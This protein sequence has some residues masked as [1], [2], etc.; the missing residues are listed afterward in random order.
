MGMALKSGRSIK[1]TCENCGATYNI[2]EES[3][4]TRDKGEL[5]CTYCGLI[6]HQWAGGR[7]CDLKLVSEPTKKDYRKLFEE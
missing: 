2:W 7:V 3:Y 5:Q 6:L 1:K 4:P